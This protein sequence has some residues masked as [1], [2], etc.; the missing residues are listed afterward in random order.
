MLYVIGAI[1]LLFWL[2]ALAL[3]VTIGAIHI[4]L[5][6]GLALLVW[7]FVRSRMHRGTA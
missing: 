7:G 4:A 6:L 1:L 2:G 5:V 3:K